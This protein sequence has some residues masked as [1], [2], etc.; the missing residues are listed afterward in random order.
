MTA[1]HHPDDTTE[2]RTA[3]PPDPWNPTPRSV[4]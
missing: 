1:D 4:T 2:E 3:P